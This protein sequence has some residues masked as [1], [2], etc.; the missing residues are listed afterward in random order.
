MIEDSS[1]EP[2][3]LSN[4]I[5]VNMLSKARFISTSKEEIMT[6]E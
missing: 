1:S 5:K 3:V 4:Y 2:F 6:K